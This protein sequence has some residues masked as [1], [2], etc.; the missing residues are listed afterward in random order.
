MAKPA[1]QT[2]IVLLA[3]DS[4]LIV[5]S[6]LIFSQNGYWIQFLFC[7]P[8]LLCIVNLVFKRRIL[9]EN[10]DETLL[11][12]IAINAGIFVG[13]VSQL[14]QSVLLPHGAHEEIAFLQG[15]AKFWIVIMIAPLGLYIRH[16]NTYYS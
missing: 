8:L 12:L 16:L 1:S 2:S 7:C 4:G 5:V 3:I 10:G 13:I 11:N 9:S 15:F 14:L 6:A